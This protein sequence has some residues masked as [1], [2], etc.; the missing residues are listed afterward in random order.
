MLILVGLFTI[1]AVAIVLG[2]TIA[3]RSLRRLEMLIDQVRPLCQHPDAPPETLGVLC[4]AEQEHRTLASGFR[5]DLIDR[6]NAAYLTLQSAAQ[7]AGSTVLAGESTR[8]SLSKAKRRYKRLLKHPEL[9]NISLDFEQAEHLIAERKFKEAAGILL[10]LSIA[11]DFL[12]RRKNNKRAKSHQRQG[13]G[14]KKTQDIATQNM[15]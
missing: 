5:E 4:T 9:K 8:R 10:D 12:Y 13:T 15:A 7:L 1:I 2:Q 14:K 3:G 6:S 11:M